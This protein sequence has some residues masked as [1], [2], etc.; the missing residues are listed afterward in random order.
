MKTTLL[1]I[2]TLL[3]STAFA[4]TDA[5]SIVCKGEKKNKIMEYVSTIYVHLYDAK[6]DVTGGS[7]DSSTLTVLNTSELDYGVV[8]NVETASLTAEKLVNIPYNGVKY[9]GYLK[10]DLET[11]GYVSAGT[12]DPETAELMIEPKYT[13]EKTVP[14]ENGWTTEVRKY[15]AVLDT[16]FDDHHGDYILLKCYSTA[17]LKP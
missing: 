16:H 3:T 7:I 15:N 8:P 14:G 17:Y 4:S 1:L 2:A 10:F 5:Y 9:K 11:K 12:F 6:L 13:V